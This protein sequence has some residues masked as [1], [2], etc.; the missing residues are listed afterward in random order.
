MPASIMLLDNK[1]TLAM[2]TPDCYTFLWALL[3]M[4]FVLAGGV[5][6][7]WPILGGI[8]KNVRCDKVD[9]KKCVGVVINKLAFSALWTTLVCVLL[10]WLGPNLW[11]YFTN[12]GSSSG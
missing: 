10:L 12:S 11:N 4:V 1:R 5:A 2:D 8:Y 7:Q 9:G 3:L 6:W